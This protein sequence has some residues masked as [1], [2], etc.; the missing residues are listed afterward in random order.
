[1]TLIHGCFYDWFSTDR[2][3]VSVLRTS[4]AKDGIIEPQDEFIRFSKR[5]AFGALPKTSRT[6]T[7]PLSVSPERPDER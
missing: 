5:Q 2:Q 7:L 6:D 1:M 4:E 3:K